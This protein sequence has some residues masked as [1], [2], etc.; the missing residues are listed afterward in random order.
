MRTKDQNLAAMEPSHY[1]FGYNGGDTSY[2]ERWM[3]CPAREPDDKLDQNYGVNYPNVFSYAHMDQWDAWDTHWFEGSAKL[4]KV[5]SQVY[6]AADARVGPGFTYDGKTEILHPNSPASTGAGWGSLNY[7]Y[8]K[9]GVADSIV[10]ELFGIG[11]YNGLWPAHGAPSSTVKVGGQRKACNF[12]FAD[13]AVRLVTI[14]EWATSPIM[15][16]SGFVNP[17]PYK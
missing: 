2:S 5:P 14:R 4:A 17:P 12:L 10:T 11:P 8:D 15:W 6:L 1:R 7:D 16:G 9:D 3:Y 13:G